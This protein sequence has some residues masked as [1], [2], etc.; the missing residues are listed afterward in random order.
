M[1]RLINNRRIMGSFVNGP[2]FNVIA[3]VTVIIMINLT[4]L[5]TFDALFPGVFGKIIGK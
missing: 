2:I 3:W 4:L 1:L 5:M